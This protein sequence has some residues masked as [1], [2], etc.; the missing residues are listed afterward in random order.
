MRIRSGF[1]SNSS[2]VSFCAYGTKVTREELYDSDEYF[3]DYGLDTF[4]MQYGD[5]I[6]GREWC[7]IGDD[8][9]KKEFMQEVEANLIKLLKREV[10]CDTWEDGYYD[11]QIWAINTWSK[12]GSEAVGI[13]DKSDEL[14]S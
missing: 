11:G 7:D 6:C 12:H 5:M 10:V 14:M 9:T 13:S 8:Q 2:S 4:R 3:R 1:V